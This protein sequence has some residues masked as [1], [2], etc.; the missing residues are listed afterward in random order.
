MDVERRL[1]LCD[2][3]FKILNMRREKNIADTI[4]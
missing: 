2:L 4:L 1:D 3:E